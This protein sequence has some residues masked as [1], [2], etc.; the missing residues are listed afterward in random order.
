MMQMHLFRETEVNCITMC[1]SRDAYA[2]LVVF[3]T[4]E[5]LLC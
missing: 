2:Y 5:I 1:P 4:A 3:Y